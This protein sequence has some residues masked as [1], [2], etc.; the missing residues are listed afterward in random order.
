MRIG[1]LGA[2]SMG[3]ALARLWARAGHDVVLSFSRDEEKLRAAAVAAGPNARTGTPSEAAAFGE[4]VALTVPWNA[5]Q[6]ALDQAGAPAGSL[7][8]KVLLSSV[9]ALNRDMSGLEVGHTTSAAE[10]VARLSPGARVVESFNSVFAPLLEGET[11][12]IGGVR[13]TVFHCGDDAPAKEA[14]SALISDAGFDPV[15]AGPLRNARYLEPFGMLM[16]QLAY[17]EGKG[18]GIAVRLLERHAAADTATP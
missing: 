16:I 3:A 17:S 11:R 2:G 10:E 14:A 12:E 13:P 6:T 9:M 7:A 1:I 18:P 15:D 5:L 8:G 4:V